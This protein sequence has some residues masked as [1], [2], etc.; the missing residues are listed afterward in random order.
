M[1]KL[2]CLFILFAIIGSSCEK[3]KNTDDVYICYD[4]TNPACVNY[5]PCHNKEEPTADFGIYDKV[6]DITRYRYVEENSILNG[7]SIKFEAE[8]EEF[9]INHTWYLGNEIIHESSVE[10]EFKNVPRPYDIEVSHVIEY[11]VDS[12]CYPNA[13]GKD[14]I[15]RTFTLASEFSDLESTGSFKVT[16]AETDESYK[17]KIEMIGIQRNGLSDDTVYSVPVRGEDMNSQSI[18][19]YFGLLTNF[20]NKGKEYLSFMFTGNSVNFITDIRLRSNE[21]EKIE[22]N[23]H[24]IKGGKGEFMMYEILNSDTINVFNATKL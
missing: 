17:M 15:S 3:D 19:D 16:N 1:N 10:R 24:F 21:K 7:Y 11:P 23:Y 20:K 14:S 13:T 9:D 5:D 8:S 12:T 2:A 22:S 4:E 18:K 6:F